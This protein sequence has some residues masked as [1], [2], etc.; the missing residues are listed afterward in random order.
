MHKYNKKYKKAIKVLNDFVNSNL[1]WVENIIDALYIM[2][3]CYSKTNNK[4][5]QAM[6]L[7]KTFAYDT[8]RAN[9]CCH[10]GDLFYE[11]KKFEPAIFWYHQASK[12]KDISFKGGFV[13]KIYYNYYPYLQLCCCY[14]YL[15]NINK[16]I[17]Y[18]NKAGKYFLTDTIK[19]NRE[20]LNSLTQNNKQ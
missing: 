9:V 16:A 14:F 7:F 20:F 6:C 2:S 8:P 5:S 10:I 17:F 12:C 4:Q 13:E 18:N 1:G 3:L 19:K 15:N 11:Q